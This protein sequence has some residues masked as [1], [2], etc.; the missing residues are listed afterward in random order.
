MISSFGWAA[1]ALD[2]RCHHMPHLASGMMTEFAV[3]AS[4]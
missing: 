1:G 2:A 3:T 4:T